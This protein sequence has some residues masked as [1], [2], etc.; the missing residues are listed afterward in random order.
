MRTPRSTRRAATC[1]LAVAALLASGCTEPK[2]GGEESGS[3]ADATDGSGTATTLALPSVGGDDTGDVSVVERF[4][5]EEVSFG[6]I[7]DEPT[8]ATGEPIKLG[9]INQEDTPM[10]SFP[11]IRLGAEAAIAFINTELGG[12]DGRPIELIACKAQFSVE[13]SQRCAQDLVTEGVVAVTGGIDITSHGAIPILEQNDLPL[14]G[15]IPINLEDMESDIA[16]LWSGGSP[17]AMVAFAQHAADQG[18]TKA[19]VAYGDYGPIKAAAVDYG[20]AVLEAHGIEVE[21][22]AFPI[23][24]TDF[25]PVIKKARDAGAGAVLVSA[26]DTACLPVMEAAEEL[27]LEATI[28]I[29][30]ACAAPAIV[31]QA[32]DAVDRVVV[33]IEGPLTPELNG[34]RV[35]GAVYQAAIARYGEEGLPAASAATVSFRSVMNIYGLM[36]GIGGDDVSSATLIAAA[37]AARGVPSFDGHDYTCDG[38]QIPSLPAL[39]APQQILAQ[40]TTQSLEP[41][42]D[43]WVDV[44]RIVQETEIG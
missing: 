3:T 31:E 40:L 25:F 33:N 13:K 20:S 10:G 34:D 11:E 21:E 38:Q 22:I 16:F 43:G 24:T 29:V 30:G 37:R 8:E 28:Y 41:A 7:P 35:D 32:G 27:E 1:L 18:V 17:G 15:G 14:L 26:A 6:T 23:T 39:C 42:S 9:M 4:A 12:I 2:P 19:A 44:P 36:I 5:G